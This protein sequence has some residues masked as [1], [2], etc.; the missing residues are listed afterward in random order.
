[1][2]TANTSSPS[3][4]QSI[5]TRLTIQALRNEKQ[6][7]QPTATAQPMTFHLGEEAIGGFSAGIV[8]TLLGFPLDLVK[9]RMQT[10]LSSSA[11]NKLST[12]SLLSHI[13]RTEGISNVYK[14]V[15]PPLLS[16]SIVN[17][18]SFTSYSYFRQNYFHG[19]DGWDYNNAL[20]GMCGAPIF[21]LVTT[22]ENFLKTQMQLDNVQSQR[23]KS[24]GQQKQIQQQKPTGRFTNSFHCAKTLANAHGLPVLYTGHVIN[25]IREAAFVGTY[26]FCYEGYKGEFRNM[27][28]GIEKLLSTSVDNN[29]STST[30]CHDSSWSTSLAIPMAGGCAGATAW[31]LTFPLDCVRAGVQGQPIPSSP[32]KVQLQKQG[33]L[34]TLKHLLKT[35]G[36][37]GLYAG[38]SPSIARAFLVSGSRFS[39]YEGALWLC[40]R[41][42]LTSSGNGQY[43]EEGP[44]AY[45]D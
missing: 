4:S 13:L 1:M 12:I 43:G 19:Q 20:S 40:R 35:K 23:E 37:A 9:T 25:T 34:E 42:G 5:K 15:G 18:L 30:D 31:A 7:T 26:F 8:G 28:L 32:S 16:L 14:G 11:T 21:G 6:Q 2:T 24:N 36:I 45:D 10:Q 38:V 17:T 44:G 29:T 22:P 39:A 41:S 3:N 33:A 27:I